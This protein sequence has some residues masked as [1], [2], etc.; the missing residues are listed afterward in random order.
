MEILCSQ[1][2]VFFLPKTI[3]FVLTLCV[4]KFW[5]YK[6]PFKSAGLLDLRTLVDPGFTS[7]PSRGAEPWKWFLP[8][9]MGNARGRI[10]RGGRG[11]GVD[12]HCWRFGLPVSTRPP[13][14]W[15]IMMASFS[16]IRQKLHAEQS[17]NAHWSRPF[18]FLKATAFV[19]SYKWLCDSFQ[20]Q[21][22]Y[23]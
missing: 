23:F 19:S 10:R 16:C 17:D 2:S 11:R 20:R 5:R 9:G 18:F 7:W 21:I 1:S 15:I 22:T 4:T 6:A 13:C 3:A 8:T 14:G 12:A